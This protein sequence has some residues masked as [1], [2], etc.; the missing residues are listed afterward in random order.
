[1]IIGEASSRMAYTRLQL[2]S[3]TTSSPG[4]TPK[5]NEDLNLDPL[6]D[7][8]NKQDQKQ[9]PSTNRQRGVLCYNGWE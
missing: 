2:K 9:H 5:N 1:M 7:L 4:G 6:Q 3:W 8:E